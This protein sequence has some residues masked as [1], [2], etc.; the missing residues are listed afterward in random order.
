[1]SSE[2]DELGPVDYLVV[3]FPGNR[4]TGEM[5]AALGELVDRDLVRVLDLLVLKKD[6]DG[7][8][9]AFELTDLDDSEVGDVRGMETAL[10]MLLSAED[11]AAVSD[12]IE[13]NSSAA[14]L[15]WENTVA[16]PFA[17]ALR[18]SGG[19]VIASGRIPVQAMPAAIQADL[20]DDDT[21]D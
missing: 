4:F 1:M 19:Q 5:G 21:G 7:T 8:L 17:S 10:A 9:D 2:V 14:L 3:E 15:I 12:A 18:H 20:E 16:S 11:V 13:P 6:A